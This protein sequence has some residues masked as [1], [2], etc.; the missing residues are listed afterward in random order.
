MSFLT[1]LSL[2]F[3]NLMAKK[4][5]TFLTAFAGSIGIMGIAAILALSNGVNNYIDKVQEDVLSSSPLTIT[6]SSFDITSIM[7]QAASYEGSDETGAVAGDDV[8]PETTIMSDI[9]TDVKT[10]DL[11]SFRAYLEGGSSGI[12]S[13]VNAITYSYGITPYI[14]K[15]DTSDGIK[16]LNPSSL[17]SIMSNGMS[18]LMRSGTSSNMGFQEM[19]D[20]QALLDE[21]YEVVRGSWPKSYDECVLVLSDSGG[22]S[23]YTLYSLGVLDPDVLKDLLTATVNSEKVDVPDAQVEVTYDDILNLSFKVVNLCNTFTRSE[24]GKTWTDRSKDEDFMK[25]QVAKGIDLH[26]VGIVRPRPTASSTSLGEGIAYRHDL[27]LHLMDD[28]A[29]S[30]IVKE[31][32]DDP[33]VDV[34]TGKT[35]DELQEAQSAEL[36]MSSLFSIYEDAVTRAFSIDESKMQVEGIDPSAFDFSGLTLEGLDDVDITIDQD[37]IAQSV[38]E[39]LAQNIP[40]PESSDLGLS[41]PEGM[42]DLMSALGVEDV[43]ELATLDLTTIDPAVLASIDPA[44]LAAVSAYGQTAQAL[45]VAVGEN[46][47]KI[48]QGYIAYLS[49]HLSSGETPSQASYV[50]MMEDYLSGDGKQYLD[51]IAAA[52]GDDPAQQQATRE[53]FTKYLT[54]TVAPNVYASLLTAT[55]Q[56]TAQASAQALEQVQTQLQE[57]LAKTLSEQLSKVMQE[58]MSGLAS[59][60]QNAVSFDPDVFAS[61]IQVKMD[62]DDLTSLLT[63]YMNAE[64]LTY[65]NNFKKLGYADV[66]KPRAI[67]IYAKSF[68]DKQEVEDIIA[69]YNTQVEDAGEKDKSISYSDITGVLMGS[70]SDIINMISMVLI[71]FVSVSLV[72]SSI[73]IGIITYISVLERRKEIGILRA[74]GASKFNVANIF[75][76]ET[77]IEGLFAGLL[78]IAA[79]VAASIPINM[80]VERDHA[81]QNIMS[82]PPRQALLLITISVVLTFIAGLI[83]SMAA[84]RRDPVE[85][86]RSE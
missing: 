8:I 24:D 77:V 85:A 44:T 72:V 68:D 12:E 30:T 40:A 18:S 49:Q 78:A 10:N 2:S 29:N 22:V 76:A 59:K 20:D 37:A 19:L 32:L 73:M 70:V 64:E 48:V 47:P 39:S 4:G 23:D 1:A 16:Q 69:A 82:L 25:G 33:D 65:D 11:E 58:Q 57:Q 52:T 28:A 13:H 53:A 81:V 66:D 61:A 75:N 79:V 45:G 34:F 9:L 14:Y 42:S 46:Y 62:Q 7:T 31:Q 67:S 17:S 6:E 43:S 36:D 41:E 21:Q 26:V 35:F 55:T 56:A 38:Q 3:A 86:L 50:D 51:A 74:M 5:R 83:P 80:I 60:I 54:R 27:I 15:A 71:A 63:N 84:S